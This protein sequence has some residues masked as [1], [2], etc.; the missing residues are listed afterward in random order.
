MSSQQNDQT[1]HVG[2]TSPTVGCQPLSSG[3]RNEALLCAYR[4]RRN[5]SVPGKK[6]NKMATG[7]GSAI[8]SRMARPTTPQG[9]RTTVHAEVEQDVDFVAVGT[10]LGIKARSW[11]GKRQL[12]TRPGGLNHGGRPNRD[13]V[14][15]LARAVTLAYV[16]LQVAHNLRR[17]VVFYPLKG[18]KAGHCSRDQHTKKGGGHTTN[19]QTRKKSRSQMLRIL[20]PDPHHGLPRPTVKDDGHRRLI[21]RWRGGPAVGAGQEREQQGAH[22]RFVL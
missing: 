17:R 19:K 11:H 5:R 9:A 15:Q 22:R 21:F 6:K 1:K 7:Q 14:C 12:G 4:S 10:A 13:V 20:S 2:E 8:P 3:H 16:G 18:S